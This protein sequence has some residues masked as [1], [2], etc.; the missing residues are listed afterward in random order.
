M[1]NMKKRKKKG[2]RRRGGGSRENLLWRG[3]EGGGRRWRC[4]RGLCSLN[5]TFGFRFR[6][7]WSI[8]RLEET[9]FSEN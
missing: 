7:F 6:E 5:R 2:S 1:K 4:S 9:T 8:V 3:G